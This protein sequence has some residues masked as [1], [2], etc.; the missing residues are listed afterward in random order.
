VRVVAELVAADEAADR[1]VIEGVVRE[2]LVHELLRNPVESVAGE[3]CAAAKP[4]RDGLPVGVGLPSQLQPR[5]KEPP[6]RPRVFERAPRV[7]H[8]LLADH[9]RR[10]IDG[11]LKIPLPKFIRGAEEFVE[12]LFGV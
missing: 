7:K 12:G 9:A 4:T 1:L 10:L 8:E 3:G 11:R 5:C 2:G 6:G